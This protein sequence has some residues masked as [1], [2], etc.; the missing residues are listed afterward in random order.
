MWK[1]FHC[2]CGCETWCFIL[3]LILMTFKTELWFPFGA[4]IFQFLVS[5]P[6]SARVFTSAVKRRKRGHS[7]SSAPIKQPGA[8]FPLPSTS[9]WHGDWLSTGTGLSFLYLN[10]RFR[11][12]LLQKWLLALSCPP[13]RL[14]LA[15]FFFL[16]LDIQLCRNINTLLILDGLKMTAIGWIMLPY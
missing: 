4:E 6:M 10:R 15:S 13:V 16:T 1:P 2:L 9:W 7:L 3:R 11:K 12:T 14:K 8:I 5:Y